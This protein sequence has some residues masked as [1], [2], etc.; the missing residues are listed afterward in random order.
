M[1]RKA[2]PP[3]AGH[4]EKSCRLLWFLRWRL[5]DGERMRTRRWWRG[6]GQVAGG[7]VGA[8]GRVGD[9]LAAWLGLGR[10]P[11]RVTE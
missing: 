7:L 2:V 6:R 11:V 10:G 9:W 3:P 8:G 1:T 5:E 4:V